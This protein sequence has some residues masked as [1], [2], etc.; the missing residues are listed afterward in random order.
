[1]EGILS[2]EFEST[3]D[4]KGRFLMPSLLKKQLP[5]NELDQLWLNRAIDGTKCLVLFPGT[6]WNAEVTRIYSKNR[7]NPK[8]EALGRLFQAGAV[9]VSFDASARVL[10]PKRLLEL[11]GIQKEIVL[12]AA[13][14]RIEIWSKE[15]YDDY[16]KNSPYSL[17][18]LAAEIMGSDD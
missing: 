5:Q 8:V 15:A 16:L 6:V 2:G 13:L 10:I 17:E 18:Q 4:A 14:D 12:K 9:P 11:S 7:Y 3:V 1:M